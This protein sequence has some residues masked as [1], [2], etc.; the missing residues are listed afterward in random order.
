MAKAIA[1]WI[2]ATWHGEYGEVQI[3]AE[4]QKQSE[5]EESRRRG[6]CYA[7]VV[8]SVGGAVQEGHIAWDGRAYTKE[9]FQQ[10]H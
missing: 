6:R 1:E 3:E 9:E 2:L 7:T 5:S 4:H 8:R 10:W